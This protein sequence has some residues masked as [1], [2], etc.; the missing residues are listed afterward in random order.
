MTDQELYD[1]VAA[2]LLKQG[3]KAGIYQPDGSFSCMYRDDKGRQCAAGCLLE[4]EQYTAKL[5]GRG[6]SHSTVAVALYKSIGPYNAELVR[7]LQV[8]HDF[9]SPEGWEE[10]LRKLAEDFKLVPYS[11]EQHD[12]RAETEDC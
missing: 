1:K 6:V 8:V 2:H 11:V 9:T 4:P 10:E 12:T 3:D 7:E 5:E